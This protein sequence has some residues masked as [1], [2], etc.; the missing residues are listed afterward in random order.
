VTR[1]SGP[2]TRSRPVRCSGDT[3]TYNNPVR[4]VDPTGTTPGEDAASRPLSVV[5]DWMRD[6]LPGLIAAPLA[7][8]V[9]V[10]GGMGQ[11]VVGAATWNG[12]KVLSGLKNMGLGA[13]SMVGLKEFFTDDWI[14]PVEVGVH[15]TTLKMPRRMARDI[16]ESSDVQE[17]L[18]PDAWKNGMHAWHAATNAHIVN[19]LGPVGAPFLWLAG[20]V[21]ESPIDWGSFQ[22]EQSAQGTVNHVLD[23][24]TDIVANT[25]GIVL[26]LILPRRIAVQ[27]AAVAGNYIIGPG[28]P[29]PAG[30][31]T[32]GYTGRPTDAWGQYPGR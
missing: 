25:W 17:R 6:W 2:G 22:S 19:R 24:S 26:G 11:A 1:R 32:G 13:L 3:Y 9:D 18:A 10:V 16:K 28:D 21:H 27:A 31:G 8:L 20:L 23:S 12:D 15:T 29:D 5:S 14:N 7:G 4:L 30:L